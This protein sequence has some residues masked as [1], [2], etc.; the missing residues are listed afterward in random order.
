MRMA[1]VCFAGLFAFSSI[2]FLASF[3]RNKKIV[4]QKNSKLFLSCLSLMLLYYCFV[5]ISN[6]AIFYFPSPYRDSKFSILN[7]AAY[8]PFFLLVSIIPLCWQNCK[9]VK[10]TGWNKFSKFLFSINCL[11][12]LVLVVL[13][14]YWKL[15]NIF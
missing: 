13:F 9:I 8:I 10:T 7:V 4:A 2:F 14:S 15:Y 5:L 1:L 6:Q 3:I 12:Y 11:T